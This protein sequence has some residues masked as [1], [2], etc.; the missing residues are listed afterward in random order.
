MSQK[1]PSSPAVRKAYRHPRA[2]AT[3][4]TNGGAMTAPTLEPLSKMATASPRSRAGNHSATVLLAPGQ[5]QPSPRPSM[6]RNIASDLTELATD[7]N[8][9]E[10]DHQIM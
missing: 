6:K 7:G 2:F 1:N 4:T 5:L 8:M 3:K 9:L 10:I